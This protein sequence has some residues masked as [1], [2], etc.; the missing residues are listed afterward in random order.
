MGMFLDKA[1]IAF[2]LASKGFRELG[3]G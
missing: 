2:G 1:S 3:Q